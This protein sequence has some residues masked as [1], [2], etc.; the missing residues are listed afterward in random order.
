DTKSQNKQLRANLARLRKKWVDSAKTLRTEKIRDF[1]FSILLLSGNDVPQS[2]KQ[3]IPQ[4][5]EVQELGPDG[6][7]K[8][9]P[10]PAKIELVIG[11]ADSL[12]I[13]ANSVKAAE[14]IVVRLTGGSVPALDELAAFQSNQAL[15]RDAPLYAWLNVKA[16]VDALLRQA[17]EK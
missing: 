16:V 12:L 13:V 17:A 1:E 5:A 10:P 8:V 4:P 15:W 3:I 7:P 14:K 2:L 6:E 11:Q 9:M